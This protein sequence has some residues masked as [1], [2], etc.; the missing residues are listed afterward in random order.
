MVGVTGP[1]EDQG[2]D[3]HG[4][5]A[6]VVAPAVSDHQRI[7]SW[8]VQELQGVRKDFGLRF[9]GAN[10]V[11][12]DHTVEFVDQTCLGQEWAYVYSDVGHHSASDILLS[13][14]CKHGQRVVESHPLIGHDGI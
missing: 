8:Y 9:D 4:R 6:G 13:K 14:F 10:L 12:Q 2:A 1:G 5:S 7:D 3:A 11:R